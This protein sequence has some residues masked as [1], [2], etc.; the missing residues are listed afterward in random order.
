MAGQPLRDALVRSLP[1]PEKGS[2]IIYDGGKDRIRGFGLRVTAAGVKAFILNYTVDGRE[3]RM[4]IGGYPTWSVAAAREE[5][6]KLRQDVDR[7][8]DPLADREALREA[9][10]VDQLCDRYLVEHAAKKRTEK[11]LAAMIRMYIRDALGNRKV[12]SISFSD[13]DRLHRKITTTGPYMANRVLSLLS[14]MFALA[15]HWEMRTDNPCRGIER[16]HEERRARHLSGEE[17]RRLTVALAKHPNQAAAN[18]IR[19][20]LLTG[21]RRGEVLRATWSQFDLAEGI[22][23]KPSSHTKQKKEHRIPLSAAA[24]LLLTQMQDEAEPSIYVFANRHRDVLKRPWVSLCKAADLHGVRL[25]DLRHSYASILASAGL[26]LPVIGALLG[27]TQPSTTERY[28]HLFDDPLRAAAER[29]GA[30]VTE[31]AGD[32]KAGEVISLPKRGRGR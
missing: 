20:L 29:V 24:R 5:A 13:I 4:T 7:G 1:A 25:H 12:A 23:T 2:K 26:S 11:D 30:I 22:W 16:N 31:A 18:A 32:T 6:K 27:H 14:K 9:P 28:A 15:I 3:R 8:I 17:L 19:L 10:T 21:A